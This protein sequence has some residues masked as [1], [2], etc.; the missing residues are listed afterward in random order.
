MKS[1]ERMCSECG[2]SIPTARLNEK[3]NTT[4]CVACK[5]KLEKQPKAKTR[6]NAVKVRPRRNRLPEPL[7]KAIL[8]LPL[9]KQITVGWEADANSDAANTLAK[10]E[11]HVKR[12]TTALAAK[13]LFNPTQLIKIGLALRQANNEVAAI[14]SNTMNAE[15]NKIRQ[16][17]KSTNAKFED[18]K[19]VVSVKSK[20]RKFVFTVEEKLNLEEVRAMLSKAGID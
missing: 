11:A 13:S 12:L 14:V 16:A 4:L 3:P 17:L 8:I 1:Q 20:K 2:E 19:A 9:G 10:V 15:A 7:E 6:A 18:K 5:T